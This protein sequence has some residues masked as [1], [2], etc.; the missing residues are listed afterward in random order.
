MNSSS[1]DA[2]SVIRSVKFFIQENPELAALLVFL[3][4]VLDTLYVYRIFKK[5]WR[6]SSRRSDNTPASKNNCNRPG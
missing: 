6:K 1:L 5:V 2:A 3:I 4:I